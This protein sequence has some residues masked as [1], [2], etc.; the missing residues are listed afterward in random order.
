MPP[1][2]LDVDPPL[3][4]ALC[5]MEAVEIWLWRQIL[6]IKCSDRVRNEEVSQLVE[7]DRAIINSI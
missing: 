4:L 2:C 5:K 1:P 3:T 7:K 6:G